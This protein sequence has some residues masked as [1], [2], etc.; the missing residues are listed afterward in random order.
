MFVGLFFFCLTCCVG[1]K[2]VYP[3]MCV[4]G[5]WIYWNKEG[6]NFKRVAKFSLNTHTAKGDGEG[7]KVN[8]V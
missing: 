5:E 2:R 4:C 8:S 6:V 7:G 1:E 3:Y